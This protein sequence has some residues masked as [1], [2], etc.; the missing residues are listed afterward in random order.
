[1]FIGNGD[2]LTPGWPS[3]DSAPRLS[4]AQAYSAAFT[5][6]APLPKIPIHPLSW[7]DA[8]PILSAIRGGP[9]LPSGWAG[10]VPNA[11]YAVGPGP[12]VVRLRVASNLTAAPIRQILAVIPGAVEPDR[13]VVLGSHRDA[14]DLG[15]MDPGSGTITLLNVAR[16]LGRLLE[17]G[18][19]PRRTL[20]LMSHDAEEQGLVG[21][22]EWVEHHKTLLQH[23]GVAYLNVDIAVGGRERL[24]PSGTPTLEPL[25]RR[26]AMQV[27]APADQRQKGKVSLGD[28]WPAREE[29]M[30]ALG[31]G[32]DFTA[33]QQH[34]G[35]AAAH[36][37]FDGDS[38]YEGVYH[39]AYDSYYWLSHFGDPGFEYHKCMSQLMGLAA[40]HL[41]D[42]PLLEIDWR[43]YPAA[44]RQNL[45]HV[46]A[47]LDA[48]QEPHPPVDFSPL[49]RAIS[50]FNA[51]VRQFHRALEE[52]SLDDLS[53][54]RLRGINDQ[55][56]FAERTFI[57]YPKAGRGWYAHSLFS[58][59]KYD[60]Y[61]SDAFPLLGDAIHDRDW[62]A[63]TF[64]I[65]LL[66]TILQ[67][68]GQSLIF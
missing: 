25:L 9:A 27:P 67:I 37:E 64:Q 33:F 46:R 5:E 11:T 57:S 10:G 56:V 48:V 68:A 20:V 17:K 38:G 40:L 1:M 60:G 32:S 16:G 21:S 44:L 55:L 2:P 26:L 59:G 18:W 29:A 24:S 43:G 62:D 47:A 31:S 36:F 50:Q 7:G 30:D 15:A 65:Q 8:A 23:R 35:L 28:M 61:S 54:E 49:E 52:T 58:P 34:A 39:S 12:A 6:D 66:S 3:V 63:V 42:Q 41:A 4:M 22:V 19:R 14:W 53:P 45:A 13:L 51:T